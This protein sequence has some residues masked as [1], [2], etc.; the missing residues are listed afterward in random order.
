M[1]QIAQPES[2]TL[3]DD[4][5]NHL[6][7]GIALFASLRITP[8]GDDPDPPTAFIDDTFIVSETEP[9]GDVYVTKLEEVVN[10]ESVFE[11]WILK[12]RAEKMIDD[13][14]QLDLRVQ[15]R[16]GYVDETDQGELIFEELFESIAFGIQDFEMTMTVPD[17][18]TPDGTP[19]IDPSTID[20]SDLFVRLVADL[21]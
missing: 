3:V 4:W 9:S 5:D 15:L 17:P 19:D 18:V 13:A 10:P 14:T 21:S 16:E 20:T 12:F 2:D 8:L 1:T 7:D 6:G 11:S